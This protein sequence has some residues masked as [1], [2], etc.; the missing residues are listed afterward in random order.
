MSGIALLFA[1]LP[2]VLVP[3]QPL[4]FRADVESVYVDVFVSRDGEPVRGLRAEN[5]ELRDNDVRQQ[6]RLVSVDSVP[7]AVVLVFDRSS[8]VAG[9]R[10]D[11]LRSAADAVLDGLR[12]GDQAALITFNYE[13]QLQ[14]GLT[15]ELS[16]IRSALDHV[17]AYGTTALHDA[18]YA[19]LALPARA[20][21]PVIVLFSDG[22]DNSSW[23]AAED[24]WSAARRSD[25]L[26]QAVAVAEPIPVTDWSRQGAA[27]EVKWVEHPRVL[28]LR[29]IA[30]ATGGRFWQVEKTEELK[31]TFL[32]ILSELRT[33]YLLSFEPT[34]VVRA[35]QHELEV[36]L[37]G[38][39]GKIRSRH[40]YYLPASR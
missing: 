11:H 40:S 1:V 17:E 5:F 16:R 2:S 21:R 15:E 26:L 31:E 12:P 3:Q 10:L 38:A 6:I 30:E 22:E 8:S 4:S 20:A 13:V 7:T 32:R 39:S 25:A 35:G 37:E 19:A 23:L 24:V 33:R 28:A 14:V 36:R 18:A 34:G 29:R 27:L 9:E